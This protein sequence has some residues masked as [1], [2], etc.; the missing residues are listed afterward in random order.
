MPI[1]L[2]NIFP[3]QPHC[4]YIISSDFTADLFVSVTSEAAPP[5]SCVPCVGHQAARTSR[6]DSRLARLTTF[7]VW[8]PKKISM[9]SVD[10]ILAAI[11][12]SP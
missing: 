5:K 12:R 3:D 2:G 9:I 10:F 8:I 4:F 7:A 1:M 11:F 6:T